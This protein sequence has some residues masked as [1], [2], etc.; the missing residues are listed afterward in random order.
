MK[1]EFLDDISGFLQ[2]LKKDS[3][4]YRDYRPF[5]DLMRGLSEGSIDFRWGFGGRL[6][7][8][9]EPIKKPNLIWLRWL[10]SA[11]IIYPMIIPLVILD[12]TISFYQRICF[13]LWKI[14]QIKRSQYLVIDRHRL[15]YLDG[16]Q[17]LN[18]IYCGYANGVLSYARVIAGE[19]E[20]YWCPV[21]HE[22][23]IP[24]PHN[25]YIEFADY[26]DAEG[27]DSLHTSGISDWG[28]GGWN[29]NA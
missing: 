27:W 19:T 12:I 10:L 7:P 18:C 15:S 9:I 25:F 1:P 2:R 28:N 16:F 26:D 21:K 6:K 20:R 5:E 4:K 13:W 3:E 29:N 8:H 14:P 24:V 11:P 23:D 22:T 17:K